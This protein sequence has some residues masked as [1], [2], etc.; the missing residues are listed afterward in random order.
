MI[1]RQ[2]NNTLRRVIRPIPMLMALAFLLG[3][4][5]IV[6]KAGKTAVNAVGQ[7]ADGEQV[8][9]CITPELREEISLKIAEHEATYGESIPTN[10]LMG[11]QPYTFYPQ[12]GNLNEDLTLVNFTD[13]TPASPFP[14]DYNCGRRT[15]R[16]HTGID[17]LIRG[18]RA[19]AIGVPVFAALDGLVVDARDG[20]PDMNVQ[21][22]NAPPNYVILF[23]G[24]AHYSIYL[25][26]KRGS[27]RKDGGPLFLP[28]E[29]IPAGTQIGLTGSSGC[30]TAPH[31]HF[32]SWFGGPDQQ[33][34]YEP[35]A[36]P[37]NPVPSG[38]VNQ[39]EVRR[40]AYTTEVAFSNV[41]FTGSAA[42]PFDTTPRINTFL[43]GA[44]TI[45]F[46]ADIANLPPLS[47]YRIL[48]F[49]PSPTPPGLSPAAQPLDGAFN[50]TS[51]LAFNSFSWPLA[52]DLDTPGTWV[53]WLIVNGEIPPIE[54][55]YFNIVS[56]PA[57]VINYPPSPVRLTFDPAQPT[58]NDVLF[59][60]IKTPFT[61]RD[62]N[63][64][65]VS[66]QY[67]WRVNGTLIRNVSSGALSDAIPKGRVRAGDCVT[68]TVTP[69]DGYTFGRPTTWTL[70]MNGATCSYQI[71]STSQPFPA[72][73][74]N[75]SLNVTA[76]CGCN[77]TAFRSSSWIRFTSDDIGSG[78]GTL[79]YSVD[80]NTSGSPRTGVIM[81]QDNSLRL[82]VTQA[83]AGVA[84]TVS[85][86][87]YKT[88]IAS[89][90]IVA[91]FGSRLA[92]GT[93]SAPTLPLPFSLAGTTVRIKDSA[94]QE[95]SA[96][97]FFASPTQ[98]NY[99]IP[100]GTA[101]GAATVTITSG[102]GNLS[103]GTIQVA[104]A[105]PSLFTLNQSGSGPAT[106]LDALAF[107]GPPFA[108]KRANGEPN[109]LAFFGTGFGADA[110]DQDGNISSNISV[111][112][113]GAPVTVLYAGRAPGFVGLNQ[114][115]VLLP[116]GITSGTHTVVVTRHGVASNAVTVAIR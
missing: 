86:A 33:F 29:F 38:W 88:A 46:R 61:F 101:A 115:N 72:S 34:R 84:T 78:N 112:I 56:S 70:R 77:W 68:C 3:S 12:A 25:H 66:Y 103:L 7:P 67:A 116:A 57:E 113:D 95:R 4:A 53:V 47:T 35:F 106:A 97:L 94:G 69:F 114:L 22:T 42:F 92:T 71:S 79:S 37:C 45:Y 54:E 15:Y 2:N 10:N 80:P 48:V 87:S 6:P 74:G 49:R 8:P 24:N 20:N 16:G 59:C 111:T 32:E 51:A 58:V 65:F 18:F 109:I 27:V 100:A 90:T 50:N 19:Q 108:G 36:G 44:R 105:A 93:Q 43:P 31:L 63:Y 9:N 110:T 96:P 64:D 23:H 11:G 52:L 83:A 28:N 82:T 21:C 81:V 14:T 26:F 30:S 102:D 1:H 91:A 17:S 41:P 13:L 107:T 60:R 40:D 98:V 99:Q 76:P 5:F 89:K 62:P 85:A 73:G 39:P 55:A 75:G 104:S